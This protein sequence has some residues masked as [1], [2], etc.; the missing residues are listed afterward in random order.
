LTLSLQSF[1][2]A[3]AGCKSDLGKGDAGMPAGAMA[4]AVASV[5]R[6]H[7]GKLDQWLRLRLDGRGPDI[8]LARE[9]A[10]GLPA[11]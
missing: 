4:A 8:G 6:T 10:H 7:V 1:A 3:R 5:Y 11:R 9:C 2:P